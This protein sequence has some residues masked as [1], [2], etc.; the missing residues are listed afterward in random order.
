MT[1]ID[2]SDWV[3]R[4]VITMEVNLNVARG[5]MTVRDD[6]NLGDTSYNGSNEVSGSLVVVAITDDVE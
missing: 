6:R 3:T 4:L 2:E 5:M 1:H